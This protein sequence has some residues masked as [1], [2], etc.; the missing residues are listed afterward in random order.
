MNYL[1][2]KTPLSFFVM[3][4]WRDE[5]FSYVMARQG[6]VDIL[7]TS[8]QDFAPPLYYIVLHYWMLIFGTS[9]IAL[10][11]LSFLMYAL[12]VFVLF[13]IMVLILKV[14]IKRAL[15]YF[16][17]IVTNPFLIYYA[18]EARMYM[19]AT[20]LVAL[21]Y[22]ALW[23]KNKNLYFVSITLALY[24]HYFTIFIFAAQIIGAHYKDIVKLFSTRRFAIKLANYKLL[25]TT[26]LP[27]FLILPWLIYVWLNHDFSD[28][29]FWILQP[30]L[31]DLFY[32]PFIL[33]TGYERVF[34]TYYHDTTGYISFHTNL[35][36][37]LG[38]IIL[39]PIAIRKFIKKSNY[40]ANLYL[41]TFLPA[42]TLFIWSLIS[43]PVYLPRYIIISAP[44]LLLL[45]ITSFELI[46]ERTQ[47]YKNWIFYALGGFLLF[48]IHLYS[49][50]NIQYHTKR[51][52]SPLYA[53]VNVI[54]A[55]ID[56]IYLTSELDFHLAQ[57]YIDDEVF[58]FG[59][60]YDEIPQYV[61]KTLIPE[62][63]VLQTLP[64]YPIKAFIIHYDWYETL[65]LL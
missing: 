25:A 55:P 12:L 48:V 34:A 3:D 5:A 42:I 51:S 50:L 7:R 49:P 65:S 27:F 45:I 9:E 43:T 33:F 24:T 56:V 52:V 36:I 22:F 11:S 46:V 16:L 6:I 8:A 47:Q 35:N 21:S 28:A 60:S 31:Q 29:R 38:I 13:E 23:K 61:G 14:P 53:E 18:F 20:F 44:G 1:F 37:I 63:K 59:K 58:I 2:T 32:M 40:L 19:M 41:W 62:S 39:L 17:I 64:L 30:S 4:L 15:L 10:R 26:L 57:Y 54:R